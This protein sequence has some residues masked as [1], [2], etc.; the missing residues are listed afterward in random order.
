MMLGVGMYLE[1]TDSVSRFLYLMIRDTTVLRHSTLLPSF[2]FFSF[3]PVTLTRNGWR[4]LVVRLCGD[5]S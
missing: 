1:A 4:Q 3:L 5:R 2:S